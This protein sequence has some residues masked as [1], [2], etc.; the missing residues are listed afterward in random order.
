MAITYQKAPISELI[1]GVIFNNNLLAQE[2]ILFEL[3]SELKKEYP[4]LYTQPPIF[5]EELQGYNVFQNINTASAG[6]SL[7]RLTS[8]D[9][10]YLL[11]LQQNFILLNWIRN[12]DQKVGLYPGFTEVF[13]KFK[14]IFSIVESKFASATTEIDLYRNIKA[15]TLHYQDRVFYKAH[16]SDLSAIEEI[17]NFKIPSIKALDDSLDPANNIFSKFTIPVKSLNGYSIVS[18]NT[19][20]SKPTNEQILIVECRLK[21]KYDGDR[22]EGWF[23][24]AHETQVKFFENFFTTKI[25]DSWKA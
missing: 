22:L 25:L 15:F 9:K 21:G 20:I 4:T 18:I 3:I 13:E 24:N 2:Y 14:K 12:D 1:F 17:I 19:G 6:F 23:K 8:S 11:Q 7:Y 5:E 10:R 16:I